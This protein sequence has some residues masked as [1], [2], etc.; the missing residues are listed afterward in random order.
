[1]AVSIREGFAL[2]ITLS[3]GLKKYTGV[4]SYESGIAE[5]LGLKTKEVKYKGC[6]IC[7]NINRRAKERDY[8]PIEIDGVDIYTF[9][10]LVAEEDE[11]I[12]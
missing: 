12:A 6:C 8:Y 1:M 7:G 10:D 5:R 11:E 9:I 3:N 2:E 4:M